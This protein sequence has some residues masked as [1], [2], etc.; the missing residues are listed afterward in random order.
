MVDSSFSVGLKKAGIVLSADIL[1]QEES[2]LD[3]L[4]HWNKK[5]NLTSICDRGRAVEKHLIDSLLLLPYISTSTRLL[6]MGSGGGLPGIP[7][8]IALSGLH[9]VSIDG[10]GKKINFQKHVSRKLGLKNLQ[11]IHTRLED[12]AEHIDREPLF[13]LVTARAFSSF[14]VI[15]G[16]A[17]QW[18]SVG[19]RLL[20]M[21]GP[22]GQK[23][24][25]AAESLAKSKGFSFVEL[26][27]YRLPISGSERQLVV[28][29]KTAE[30]E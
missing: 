5:V 26:I 21:K 13:D 3:E 22:D 14:D 1:L 30:S 24:W 8:A 20:A 4:L 7:L 19:G 28:L 15:L 2:F 16:F 10:V 18:L 11:P 29:K 6:D 27:K 23:E 17:A 12:L 9:V 25:Q